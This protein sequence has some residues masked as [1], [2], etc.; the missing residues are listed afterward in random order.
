[1]TRDPGTAGRGPSF[2]AIPEKLTENPTALL[3]A[4]TR[5]RIYVSSA[6]LFILIGVYMSL[7]A[8]QTGGAKSRPSDLADV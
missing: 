2:F 3:E 6:V 1:M 8:C 7:D 5:L 4:L